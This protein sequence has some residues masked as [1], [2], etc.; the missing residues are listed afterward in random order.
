MC[1]SEGVH[2]L[3]FTSWLI[4][5]LYTA[6][7]LTANVINYTPR[8]GNTTIWE[9]VNVANGS[10]ESDNSIIRVNDIDVFSIGCLQVNGRISVDEIWASSI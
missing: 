3:L 1:V 5:C 8:L 10:A 2:N 9:K 6:K 4:D 7:Q